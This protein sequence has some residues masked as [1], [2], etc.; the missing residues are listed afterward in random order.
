MTREHFGWATAFIDNPDPPRI[1]CRAKVSIAEVFPLLSA[2]PLH[3]GRLNSH[4]ELTRLSDHP[5]GHSRPM[6][7]MSTLEH[8]IGMTAMTRPVSRPEYRC[9]ADT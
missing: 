2:C 8:A 5:I 1:N 9:G 7:C 4:V 3:V 6:K